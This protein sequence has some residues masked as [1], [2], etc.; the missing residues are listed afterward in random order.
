MNPKTKVKRENWTHNF[1]K[2]FEN[3]NHKLQ[4][5]TLDNKIGHI[6]E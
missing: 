1:G 3:L 4:K 2:N 5:M 6:G